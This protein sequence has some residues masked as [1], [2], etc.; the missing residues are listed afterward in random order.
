MQTLITTDRVPRNH[1]LVRDIRWDTNG[2]VIP[3]LPES[4]E[5]QTNTEADGVAE[6][7]SDQYGFPVLAVGSVETMS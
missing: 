5:L 7:L 4:I 6:V 3:H 2:R 1:L